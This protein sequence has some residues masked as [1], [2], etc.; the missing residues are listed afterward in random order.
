MTPEERFNDI[1]K[2]TLHEIKASSLLKKSDF[3]FIR[4][5]KNPKN[6]YEE[7]AL[8]KLVELKAIKIVVDPILESLEVERDLTEN[9]PSAVN[10]IQNFDFTKHTL[11]RDEIFLRLG[12]QYEEVLERF[13]TTSDIER[14]L[15]KGKVK[16]VSKENPRIEMLGLKCPLPIHKN[17][18]CLC[19][20]VFGSDNEIGMPISW[21]VAY[22]EMTGDSVKGGGSDRK[23]VYDTVTRLNDR[24]KREFKTHDDLLTW[25]DSTIIRNY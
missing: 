18:F 8:D 17:E 25:K 14:R 16:F 4:Y 19:K 9:N 11:A 3:P 6:K 7:D 2:K 24:I 15:Q 12:P 23:S 20:I 21:G 10:I 1:L 13:S 22:E 5:R